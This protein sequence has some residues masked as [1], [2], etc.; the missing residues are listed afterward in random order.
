[1]TPFNY[2]MDYAIDRKRRR[3]KSSRSAK[4]NLFD[5]GTDIDPRLL[6]YLPREIVLQ[7][8]GYIWKDVNLAAFKDNPY[9]FGIIQEFIHFYRQDNVYIP[10]QKNDFVGA[11][12]SLF[13]FTRFDHLTFHGTQSLKLGIINTQNEAKDLNLTVTCSFFNHLQFEC[14]GYLPRIKLDSLCNRT[15]FEVEFSRSMGEVKYLPD[16]EFILKNTKHML[17][18]K[19]WIQFDIQSDFLSSGSHILKIFDFPEILTQ[20]LVSRA[21]DLNITFS[22][23][24]GFDNIIPLSKFKIKLPHLQTLTFEGSIMK[25]SF[26]F[27]FEAPEME[28]LTLK[29]INSFFPLNELLQKL[30]LKFPKLYYISLSFDDYFFGFDLL[31][32]NYNRAIFHK[33]R[34]MLIDVRILKLFEDFDFEFPSLNRLVVIYDISINYYIDDLKLNKFTKRNQRILNIEL[35]NAPFLNNLDLSLIKSKNSISKIS[36]PQKFT[37]SSSLNHLNCFSFN[38]NCPKIKEIEF[39]SPSSS[40][41]TSL[42]IYGD[43][44]ILKAH[45]F[46]KI[47]VIGQK[48][49]NLE[50]IFKLDIPLK[51]DINWIAFGF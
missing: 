47:T 42:N 5:K 39:L 38:S 27:K 22:H 51:K 30:I 31:S 28:R 12:I 19:D 32:K 46:P 8:L 48:P 44:K 23:K 33:I 15:R 50:T 36:I 34:I 4:K 17:N 11:S 37:I 24:G 20:N 25:R 9:I 13:N 3:R 16:D 49:Y 26:L 10:F 7:V 2:M 45:S 1:M 43:L 29:I 14:L 21:R 40:K 18:H 35:L 41:I 6:T